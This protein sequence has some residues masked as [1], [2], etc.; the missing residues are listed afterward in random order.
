[1]HRGTEGVGPTARGTLLE[2]LGIRQTCGAYDLADV[3]S[4]P[5]YRIDI[6]FGPLEGQG[7]GGIIGHDCGDPG[8]ELGTRVGALEHS[9]ERVPDGRCGQCRSATPDVR[10]QLEDDCG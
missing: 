4:E 3:G 2:L 8:A 9:G 7:V 1:M 6:R 10:A 5:K